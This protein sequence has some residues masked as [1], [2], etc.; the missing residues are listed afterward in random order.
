VLGAVV[1]GVPAPASATEQ[2]WRTGAE[3]GYAIV[4]LAEGTLGGFAVGAHATYGL[5]DA[6]NLRLGAD[7]CTFDRLPPASYALVWGGSVG[8]EYVIDVLDWVPYVGLS[9]DAMGVYKEAERHDLFAGFELPIGLGYQLL[10]EWTVGGEFRYRSL[11]FGTDLGPIPMLAFLAR[12][13]YVFG[14]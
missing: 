6:F 5:S 8:L 1:V 11:L 3:I 10:P 7:L 14:P 9:L 2:Q 4:A 12:S 13:E